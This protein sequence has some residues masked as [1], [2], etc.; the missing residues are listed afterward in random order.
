M[1]SRVP[2]EFLFQFEI[3]SVIHTPK[4][5]RERERERD[6][7]I[8]FDTKR[9]IFGFLTLFARFELRVIRERERFALEQVR[10]RTKV[11]SNSL[12][13]VLPPWR[14]IHEIL[15]SVSRIP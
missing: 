11:F 13:K 15:K 5:E 4:R 2:Q 7:P 10:A 9:R 3:F 6:F 1:P 14:K 8:Y 12:Y